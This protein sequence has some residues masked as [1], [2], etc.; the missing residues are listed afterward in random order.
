MRL[1]HVS[2]A[3]GPDG[4]DATAQRLA[5]RL[6]VEF[7]DGGLHPRFG[8]RNRVLPLIGG[9]YVEVV[10]VLDHPAADR[11]PFGQAVKARSE[12]GGGWLGWVVAV[13]DLSAVERRLERPAV[14]GNRKRPDG[15]ELL[16]KQIGVKGLI[17]DPQLPFFVRWE[18]DP[19]HH[20][21]VGGHDVQL[22]GLEIAGDPHRVAQW[23]GEPESHPLEDVNVVWSNVNGQPGLQ[24]V[25]FLTPSGLVTL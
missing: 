20:P 18:S 8:T 22:V 16:W 3:A 11:V 25:N 2:Y 17:N 19:G 12:M 10:A 24:A 15:V 13:D 6:G 9:H 5:D 7:V 14:Q 4:L 1:D 21:S 23:L